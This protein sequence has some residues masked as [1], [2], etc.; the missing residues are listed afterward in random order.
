MGAVAPPFIPAIVMARQRRIVRKFQEAGA[1]DAARARTPAELG[2]SDRHL[3]G[4]MAKAGVL[5]TA[6][7]SRYF[8][9]TEGLAQWQRRRRIAALVALAAVVIGS[10]I[11]LGLANL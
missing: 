7:G 5:A 3:F 1:D 10:L 11:A 6:D 8:L 4:R 2:I 9:S